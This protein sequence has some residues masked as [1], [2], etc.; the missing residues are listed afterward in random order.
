MKLKQGIGC[1]VLFRASN[2]ILHA[3]AALDDLQL[4]TS[5]LRL[6]VRPSTVTAMVPYYHRARLLL[7]YSSPRHPEPYLAKKKLCYSLETSAYFLK[8]GYTAPSMQLMLP[9][10]FDRN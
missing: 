4:S 3:V 2:L 9:K 6:D 10:M 8:L 7:L 1:D 5:V